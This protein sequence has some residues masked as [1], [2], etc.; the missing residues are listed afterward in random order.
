MGNH[1]SILKKLDAS[2]DFPPFCTRKTTFVTA[3]LL[4]AH[5]SPYEKRSTIKGQ[6]LLIKGI[7]S[8]LL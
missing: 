1:V 6:N 7:N 8:F 2:E 5:K 4:P 3:C